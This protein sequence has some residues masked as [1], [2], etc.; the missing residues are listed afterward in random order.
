[1][2]S[3]V[4]GL[5]FLLGLLQNRPPVWHPCLPGHDHL[6]QVQYGNPVVVVHGSVEAIV[7]REYLHL[8][9]HFLS[10][11]H[12]MNINLTYLSSLCLLVVPEHLPG[13]DVV[14]VEPGQR[15]LGDVDGG[16]ISRG[17]MAQDATEVGVEAQ[18]VDVDLDV[19]REGLERT[20]NAG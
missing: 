6:R 13:V 19:G 15:E 18:G 4:L 11:F 5:R 1:M 3:H 8:K 12:L 17:E 16:A 7:R 2:F 20:V 10:Q 14:G 9:N